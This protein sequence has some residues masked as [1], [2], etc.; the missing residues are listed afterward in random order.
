MIKV[1]EQVEEGTLKDLGLPDF[2]RSAEAKQYLRRVG[3]EGVTYVLLSLKE[4]LH[5]KK[6]VVLDV[7]TENIKEIRHEVE[8]V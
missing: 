2:K 7:V 4:K 1:F 5:F 8:T 3:D 6:R